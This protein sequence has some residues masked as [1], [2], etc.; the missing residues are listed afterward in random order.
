MPAMLS[1]D[2]EREVNSRQLFFVVVALLL[3]S[4]FKVFLYYEVE[5][6]QNKTDS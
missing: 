5:Q 4:L 6:L 2:Q 1:S 3:L